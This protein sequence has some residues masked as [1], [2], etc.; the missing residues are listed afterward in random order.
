MDLLFP[1]MDN[2]TTWVFFFW[3]FAQVPFLV[4]FLSFPSVFVFS[5]QVKIN[6]SI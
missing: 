5:L 2:H 1:E 4:S 3:H 6:K